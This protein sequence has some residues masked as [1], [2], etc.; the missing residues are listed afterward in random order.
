MYIVQHVH[1]SRRLETDI[2]TDIDRAERHDLKSLFLLLILLFFFPFLR[3][4][5]KRG[6]E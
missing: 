4:E 5:E 1:M 6:K 2:R 3:R